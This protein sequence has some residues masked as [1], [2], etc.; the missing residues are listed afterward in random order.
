[1]FICSTNQTHIRLYDF[2]ISWNLIGR[3]TVRRNAYSDHG[4]SFCVFRTAVPDVLIL[5][6]RNSDLF[7]TSFAFYKK[8]PRFFSKKQSVFPWAGSTAKNG[9]W[10]AFCRRIFNTFLTRLAR[11]KTLSE[12]R[13]SHQE[14]EAFLAQQRAQN[15]VK[16]GGQ[17]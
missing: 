9:W 3:R 15:T 5:P 17:T 6:A 4:P 14:I 11:K 2:V 7:V 12:K 13:N 8:T 10:R 16:G 1:M